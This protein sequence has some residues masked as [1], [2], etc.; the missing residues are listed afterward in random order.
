MQGTLNP[1]THHTSHR[2]QS[3]TT[4]SQPLFQTRHRARGV[5]GR[6]GPQLNSTQRSNVTDPFRS[7]LDSPL[8]ISFPPGGDLLG[9]RGS[10][11]GPWPFSAASRDALAA[12]T[13]PCPVSLCGQWSMVLRFGPQLPAFDAYR[14]QE[15]KH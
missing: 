3:I 4:T 10:Q 11:Q 5:V 6:S 7:G 8:I 9:C 14:L 1:I 15:L 12:T 13:M 2:R